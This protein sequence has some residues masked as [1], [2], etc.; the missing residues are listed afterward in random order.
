M[1]RTNGRAFSVFALLAVFLAAATAPLTER[2]GSMVSGP[3][4]AGDDQRLLIRIT[5]TPFIGPGGSL[6]LSDVELEIIGGKWIGYID[7]GSIQVQL[8]GEPGS[9][10][11]PWITVPVAA[12]ADIDSVRLLC[13]SSARNVQASRVTAMPV[14]VNPWENMD[15]LELWDFSCKY[16]VDQVEWYSAGYARSGEGLLRIYTLY[17]C[18]FALDSDG[19]ASHTTEAEL[20]ISFSDSLSEPTPSRAAGDP[21][22]VPG[23]VSITD[24]MDIRPEYLIITS[25]EI[26][27]ELQVLADWRSQMG[28]ASSVV[29]IEDILESY[30]GS[31]DPADL[32][33]QYLKDVLDSWGSLTHVLLAGDW[34]TVPVKSVHDSSAYE[35][36]DDG[37][38][39][40]DSYFQ[41]LDGTWDLDGNGLYGEPQ[42]IEDSIPDLVVSRLAINDPTVWEKKI[43]QIIDYEMGSGESGWGARAVLIGANTHNEGDG[44]THSEYL[45]NKYLSALFAEK[46]PMYE[47]EGTL[48]RAGVDAGISDGAAF[49][50]FVDHGGPTVWCDN[51]GA[52]VVYNDR[53]A[54]DLRNEGKLPF[55]STLA[56][57][58]TWFDDT[59][60]CPSQRFSECMGEAFTENTEGGSMAYVGSSRTSVGI[61]GVERYLPYDNGL[62]EDIARQVGGLGV[63]TAGGIHTGAK[64]HYAQSWAR[65]FSNPGNPEVSCC[66]L[67][68][69][70]LGEPLTQ[71]RTGDA[72]P[73]SVNVEHE[74]D[75]DPY[76]F[77]KVT[78]EG[79]DPVPDVNITLQNYRRGVFERGLT[80]ENGELS[81]QLVLDWFCDINLTA[82]KHDHIPHKDFIRISDVIPPETSFITEP[83]APQG[84]NGW[85]QSEP[86]V[87]LSPNEAALVHYRIGQGDYRTLNGSG[88]FTLPPLGEGEH[89][90]HFFGEDLAGN[91][92][93]ENHIPIR[94]DL[95]VPNITVY[96]TPGEG[97]GLDGSYTTEPLVTVELDGNDRGA[98]VDVHHSLDGGMK[99]A[100]TGPFFIGEGAHSLV[101]G[102]VDGSG[103]RAEDLRFEFEVDTIPPETELILRGPAEPSPSGWYREAPII[104]LVPGEEGSRTEYRFSPRQSFI[105][106][107]G[108]LTVPDGVHSFQYRSVDGPGNIGNTTT[109][110]IKVDTRSPVLTCSVEPELPDGRGGYY[111]SSPLISLGCSDDHGSSVIFRMDGGG[112]EE[113]FGRLDVPDGEHRIDV[114]AVDTAGNTCTAVTMTFKV[115]T[116]FPRTEV[117]ETGSR[118]GDWYTSKPLILLVPDEE[119]TTYYSWSSPEEALE[120]EGPIDPPGDE[121]RYTLYYWTED[122]AGNREDTTDLRFNIDSRPP[123]LRVEVMERGGSSFILDCSGSTDGTRMRYKVSGEGVVMQDWTERSLFELDLGPGSHVITVEARD[124]AGNKDTLDLVLEVDPEW[125]P[126]A[127]YGI[128]SLGTAM[129]ALLIVV[130]LVMKKK[131]GGQTYVAD[132]GHHRMMAV[133]LESHFE[134]DLRDRAN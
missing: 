130:L 2:G 40:A 122:R 42:D 24:L 18:P 1:K 128:P 134:P 75:L 37:T 132:G 30:G 34:D 71:I 17:F 90:I 33:R 72:S 32:L 14:A 76:I 19:S 46:V 133:V 20:E 16:P 123:V 82:V 5:S 48:S 50:Q 80:D 3:P 91:L 65:E 106:Y 4:A 64:T 11:V 85:F 117:Q 125:L 81:F 110:D 27:D 86:L 67:E 51:Y 69:T 55:V 66:W 77:I 25:R 73:L 22:A 12:G 129:I 7:E 88:N 108:P 111:I 105:E 60:G 119:G 109:L 61:L 87:R 47:D 59:S 84:D 58:T 23:T 120:F 38:I 49:V 78:D 62:Q 57:L 6:E 28:I 54:R 97:D 104:E 45:W 103:R 114:Y 36:W 74:D 100:Y 44:G 93:E 29:S 10:M 127:V 43:R 39:P 70:L 112:W 131:R 9:P 107:R 99:E 35:G 98:P 31:Q 115:D 13:S 56:C 21:S 52:G 102:A 126:Y 113:A 41:C 83:E 8:D 96:L 68:F 53:D 94:I 26:E 116:V 92:E 118:E 121:G 95:A 15:P 101:I 79:G 124:A 89:I 63:F